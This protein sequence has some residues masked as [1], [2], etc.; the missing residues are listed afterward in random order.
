MFH[1]QLGRNMEV[2][3]DDMLVK[4]RQMDQHFV[5]LAEAFGT[6]RKFHMKLR[7][8]KCAFGVRSGKFVGYMVI[9]KMIEVNLEQIQAIQEMKHPA[10]LNEI[11]RLAER[12]VD[13]SRKIHESF[14]GPHVEANPLK[15]LLAP[16]NSLNGNGYSRALPIAT[17]Q[18]NS[19][20]AVDFGKWVNA[21]LLALIPENEVFKF[22]W[23]NIICRYGLPRVIIS[24][25]DFKAENF[26][27]GVL[28]SIQQRL[29]FLAYPQT[30]GQVE[31]IN[32]ILVQGIKTKLMQ[33]G[34]QWVDKLPGV[35]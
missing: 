34:G 35:L 9:E 8:A 11:Q 7:P 31:V 18:V 17:G 15:A 19:S 32:R 14:C 29:T 23:K 4:N 22:L 5:D 3:I 26:K 33:A 2:Y 28:A 24:D 16:V 27:I 10:N 30:H 25:N 20:L 13:L 12:I 1:E 6:L 21:E